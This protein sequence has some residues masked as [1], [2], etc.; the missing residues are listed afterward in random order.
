MTTIANELLNDFEDSGSENEE[1]QNEGY[2]PDGDTNDYA[3]TNGGYS[4]RHENTGLE[5]DGDD[6]DAE[7][8]DLVDG[9]PSHLKMEAEE[10]EEETKARVEK[11]EL[12]GV[13][14]VRS[15][16]LLMKQLDP[17]MEV[18]RPRPLSHL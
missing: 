2:Y 8:A 4:A 12:K 7:D 17:V 16:A 18:S 6:E 1:E 5:T 3:G 10:D 15:V 9:A 14:D 13:S 11:M